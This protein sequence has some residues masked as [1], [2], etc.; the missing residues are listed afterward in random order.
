MPRELSPLFE[1]LIG[2]TKWYQSPQAAGGLLRGSYPL[3][4]H[5]WSN[6]AAEEAAGSILS[7]KGTISLLQRI[8]EQP[9]GRRGRMQQIICQRGHLPSP[10][11]CIET[12]QQKRLQTAYGM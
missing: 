4:E 12:E 6:Q 8:L 7:V 11:H 1:K 9:S 3:S 2:T 10:R 5:F